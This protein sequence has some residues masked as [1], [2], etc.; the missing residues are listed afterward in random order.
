LVVPIEA[1]WLRLQGNHITL[2]PLGMGG[3]AYDAV[4][5]RKAHRLGA[6]GIG[7]LALEPTIFYRKQRGKLVETCRLIVPFK[8][9][10]SIGSA[11]VQVGDFKT[12][13]AL[14]APGYDFGSLMETVE[15]E[16]PAGP[17]NAT[18]TANLDGHRQ[19]ATHSFTPAKQWKVYIC[20]MIHNDVGY[21]DIQPQVNELDT[22]NTDTV[23]DILDTYPFYK[24]NFE[25]GWLVDN[26]LDS[27][28]AGERQRFLDVP[29]SAAWG[30]THF[31]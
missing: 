17:A 13:K 22:R 14:A 9:G 21:T 2:I 11:T 27:R 16:P 25:T 15:I 26:F 6:G 18:L 30:S 10:F 24:F 20:S 12:S 8:K 29:G 7:A 19:R 4:S 31:I 23:L 5:L 3:I 28:P 1:S